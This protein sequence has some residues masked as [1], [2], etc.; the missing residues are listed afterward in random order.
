MEGEL[1][2]HKYPAPGNF[3]HAAGKQG[4]NDNPQSGH[5]DNSPARG[6]LGTDSGVQEVGGVI[7]DAN[8][9]VKAGEYQQQAYDEV[10]DRVHMC[11]KRPSIT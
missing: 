3:H 2:R 5:Q 1:G 6:G 4:A 11:N 10:I 8:H 9:E 7:R